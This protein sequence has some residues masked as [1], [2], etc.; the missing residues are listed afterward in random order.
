[1]ISEEKYILPNTF[2]SFALRPIFA[3]AAVYCDI[4]PHEA[5]AFILVFKDA[6]P[7]LPAVVN[8]G[9]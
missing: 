8:G 5:W 3:P 2:G 7:W 6:R 1:M 9:K 4:C